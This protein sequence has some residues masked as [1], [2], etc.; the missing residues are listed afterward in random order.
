MKYHTK[1]R[2]IEFKAEIQTA[3][4]DKGHYGIIKFDNFATRYRTK[5]HYATKE[6]ALYETEQIISRI[7]ASAKHDILASLKLD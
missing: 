1:H 6:L 2:T 7:L 3:L 5:L 4:D